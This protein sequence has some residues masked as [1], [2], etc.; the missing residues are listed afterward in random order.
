[1]DKQFD[2]LNKGE[3]ISVNDSAQILIGHRTFRAGEFAESI[4]T[5]LEYGL[6]GWTEE[7]DGWFSDQ[8]I[9]CE[10][11]RFGANGWQKGKV[12]ISLE[13]CPEEPKPEV[14][15]AKTWARDEQ[16]PDVAQTTVSHEEE[17]ELVAM[18]SSDEDE[19]EF[20]E[21]SATNEFDN[22]QTDLTDDLWDDMSQPNW[23]PN[24]Y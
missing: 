11:L 14:P 12:R 23:Q 16:E 6:G 20:P 22:I 7:K 4:K 5:Q 2:P 10:V 18:L 24:Q 13:F 1:M 15:V 9:D 17:Q 8:G 19:P 3:V 21:L